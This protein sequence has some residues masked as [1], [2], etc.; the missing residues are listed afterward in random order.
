M[1]KNAK[2]IVSNTTGWVIVHPEYSNHPNWVEM[3]YFGDIRRMD[4]ET[5]K[6]YR[7]RCIR[8]KVRLVPIEDD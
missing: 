2:E 6:K 4:D 7:P 3:D 5:L 1:I 8:V